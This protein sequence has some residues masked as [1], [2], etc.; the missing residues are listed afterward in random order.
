MGGLEGEEIKG[1]EQIRATI[2]IVDSDQSR[3]KLAIFVE[4][5][6]EGKPDQEF[7]CNQEP[8]ENL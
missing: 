7:M 8:W 4:S 5:A 1:P 6:E 2:S 3:N